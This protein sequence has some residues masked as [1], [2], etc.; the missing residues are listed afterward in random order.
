MTPTKN[1]L[2]RSTID[3]L[4]LRVFNTLF[5]SKATSG[6]YTGCRLISS[7][8]KGISSEEIAISSEKKSISSEEKRINV[9][10]KGISSYFPEEMYNYAQ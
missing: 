3:K 5:R 6:F 7:E 2:F 1:N 10:L 9:H 8:E 4:C